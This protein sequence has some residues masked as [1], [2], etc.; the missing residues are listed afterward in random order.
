MCSAQVEINIHPTPK[1]PLLDRRPH[2]HH[3][4][5]HSF[6]MKMS[7]DYI[8]PA[9][10]E[11][12]PQLPPI[13]STLGKLGD[14][15]TATIEKPTLPSLA[16]CKL[17]IPKENSSSIE[18]YSLTL[19][20]TRQVPQL[21]LPSPRQRPYRA[22]SSA[23]NARVE[24]YPKQRHISPYPSSSSDSSTTSSHSPIFSP[25]QSPKSIV[26]DAISSIR[27]NSYLGLPTRS[28][29]ARQLLQP[30]QQ[31]DQA[32]GSR[33]EDSFVQA[34][35]AASTFKSPMYPVHAVAAPISR[36]HLPH[37]G[38]A[39]APIPS[40]FSSTKLIKSSLVT[41]PTIHHRTSERPEYD[42]EEL[43]SIA[44]LRLSKPG[45]VPWK[46][47]K[48]AFQLLFPPDTL[49]RI[50]SNSSGSRSS[51][52]SAKNLLPTYSER[53]VGGLECRYYRIRT[54][55]RMGTVRKHRRNSDCVTD[56][57]RDALRNMQRELVKEWVKNLDGRMKA[58]YGLVLR[59]G[60]SAKGLMERAVRIYENK[61]EFWGMLQRVRTLA[62]GGAFA[63]RD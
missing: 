22:L 20:K 27:K 12:G 25:S 39:Q 36:Y 60:E 2:H 29:Q 54:Q 63:S 1:D 21:V 40:S 19:Q 33:R 47:V 61:S 46:E 28:Q 38:L 10:N 18:N 37:L 23:R 51:S 31:S 58:E 52:S 17:D 32:L 24:P 34:L 16:Q 5:H 9:T 7:L 15:K 3:G 55:E 13:L 14:G 62:V 35:A 53:D 11:A 4:V 6:T 57:E 8:S 42:P 43:F 44:Y 26:S 30:L 48:T 41:T 49:R 59:S 45:A 50:T 56:L